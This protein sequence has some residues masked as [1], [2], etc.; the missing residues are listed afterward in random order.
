MFAFVLCLA[1]PIRRNSTQMQPS[2]DGPG[3][4][5]RSRCYTGGSSMSIQS[6]I[7]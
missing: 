5:V 1:P 6:S 4:R 3:G 2:S 7:G